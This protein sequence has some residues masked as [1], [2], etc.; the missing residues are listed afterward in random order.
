MAPNAYVPP[1]SASTPIF[2]AE[3]FKAAELLA[4]TSLGLVL[5]DNAS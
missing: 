1:T 2:S 3:G 4:E 5:N